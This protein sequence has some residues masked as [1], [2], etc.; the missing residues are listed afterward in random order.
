MRSKIAHKLITIAWKP[1]QQNVCVSGC[2]IQPKWRFSFRNVSKN[3]KKPEIEKRPRK[4]TLCVKPFLVV[5]ILD[6]TNCATYHIIEFQKRIP[7]KKINPAE[8]F[9]LEIWNV[10]CCEYQRNMQTKLNNGW[11]STHLQPTKNISFSM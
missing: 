2:W 10:F 6:T 5:T 3:F 9:Q 4:S 1:M 8:D 7:S 11:L